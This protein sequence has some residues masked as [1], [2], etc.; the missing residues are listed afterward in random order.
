MAYD[1]ESPS[2]RQLNCLGALGPHRELLQ[3]KA[4]VQSW[5]LDRAVYVRALVRIT[6]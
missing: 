1:S 6:R 2:G 3:G 5:A 4:Q